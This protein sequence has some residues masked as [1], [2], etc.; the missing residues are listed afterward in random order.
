MEFILWRN[1]NPHIASLWKAKNTQC[2]Q[3]GNKLKQTIFLASEIEFLVTTSKVILLFAFLSLIHY[4]VSFQ[5]FSL[6]KRKLQ[7]HWCCA[8]QAF[9]KDFECYVVKISCAIYFQLLRCQLVS[10]PKYCINKII[11]FITSL[12]FSYLVTI[13]L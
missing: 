7:Q 2:F 12:S 11:P 6:A 1:K 8:V 3:K 9:Q 5:Y 4:F 10:L 13:F